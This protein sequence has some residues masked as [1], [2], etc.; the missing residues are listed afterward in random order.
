MFFHRKSIVFYEGKIPN[1]FFEYKQIHNCVIVFQYP[2]NP[3]LTFLLMEIFNMGLMWWLGIWFLYFEL[4]ML[5][6]LKFLGKYTLYSIF[7][8]G[9]RDIGIDIDQGEFPSCDS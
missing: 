9:I 7:L 3:S 2:P 8:H 5:F 1:A 4:L 6:V